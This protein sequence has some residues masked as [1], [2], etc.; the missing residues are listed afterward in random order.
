M[1]LAMVKQLTNDLK[2]IGNEKKQYN[3]FLAQI[4]YFV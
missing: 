4:T 1:L 3:G 2:R